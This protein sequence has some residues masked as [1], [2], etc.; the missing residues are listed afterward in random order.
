MKRHEEECSV[1]VPCLDRL[2]R[3]EEIQENHLEGAAGENAKR[4]RKKGTKHTKRRLRPGEV[5]SYYTVVKLLGCSY[6][7]GSTWE[8]RCE[9]GSIRHL[10]ASVLIRGN[11]KSCGC[12]KSSMVATARTIHGQSPRGNQTSEYRI[13]RGIKSRCFNPK[14]FAYKWYGARGITMCERWANSFPAFYEDMGPRPKKLSIDR[15]NNDGNYEPGNCR[16]ATSKEQA[17]NQRKRTK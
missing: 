15:I 12:Q 13:W 3:G 6:N 8:C 9:C 17:Q 14:Y 5:F 11:T 4:A 2:Q 1:E 16:W 7:G 10:K